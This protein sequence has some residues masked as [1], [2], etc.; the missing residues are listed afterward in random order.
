MGDFSK[1]GRSCHIYI[2]WNL[3]NPTHNGTRVM[4]QIVQDVGILQFYFRNT[5]G[6]YIFVGCHR[7]SEN[8]CVGLHKFTL[9]IYI[10]ISW[11]ST[12]GKKTDF[13]GFREKDE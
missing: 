6:P 13:D 12:R 11:V 9:Y 10:D 8:P 2:Q 3:S 4:C 7:M 5:L 1:R